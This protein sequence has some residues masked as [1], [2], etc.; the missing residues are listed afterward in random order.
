MAFFGS[1]WNEGLPYCDG[2]CKSNLTREEIWDLINKM[3]EKDLRYIETKISDLRLKQ[4]RKNFQELKN[5][6]KNKK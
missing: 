2:S 1:S 5:N 4:S 3:N 6:F